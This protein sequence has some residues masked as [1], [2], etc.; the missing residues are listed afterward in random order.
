MDKA[1][2]EERTSG[3]CRMDRPSAA[4]HACRV[5][6]EGGNMALEAHLERTQALKWQE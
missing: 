5:V 6:E 3:G 4:M 1:N 2:C